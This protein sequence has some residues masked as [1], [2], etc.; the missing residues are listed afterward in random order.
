GL[1]LYN[2]P[3]AEDLTVPQ[4]MPYEVTGN[5]SATE[6]LKAIVA[7]L[8]K[9]NLNRYVG[10]TRIMIAPGYKFKII[11]GMVTNFHQPQSTL[12]LL[13]S[14]FTNG[15]WRAMY[16]YALDKDYRFLS[17]GDASLLLE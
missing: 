16:D 8:D 4:W 3:D 17:Y 2:N 14:A 6:A 1:M 12:L 5:I 13:V 9:Y 10:S 11:S 15:N 7:Y